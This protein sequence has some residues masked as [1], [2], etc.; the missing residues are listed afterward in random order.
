MMPSM[1][2]TAA[3][4]QYFGLVGFTSKEKAGV[5]AASAG[6]LGCLGTGIPFAMAAKLA[7]PDKKVVL[8]QRRW[9]LRIQLHG[10]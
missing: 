2:L 9:L 5:I 7:R 4:P 3:T 10:V 1:L 6:L 8:L